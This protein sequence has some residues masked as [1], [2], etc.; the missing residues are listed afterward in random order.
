MDS[1]SA[2]YLLDL[3]ERQRVEPE[4]LRA[5]AKGYRVTSSIWEEL[6][7]VSSFQIGR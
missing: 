1:S 2:F 3:S 6:Q 7:R 5:Q 4:R